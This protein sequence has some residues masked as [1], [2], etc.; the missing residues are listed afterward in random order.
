M[1]KLSSKVKYDYLGEDETFPIIVSSSLN[2]EQEVKLLSNFRKHRSAFGWS[3]TGLKGISPLICTHKIHLVEEVKPSREMH[4]RLNPIMKDVM[5]E[6][7][8]N[9]LDAVIIYP[10][11]NRKWVSHVQVI[12]KKSGMTVVKNAKVELVRLH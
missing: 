1:K 11:S 12:P 2:K 10:I 4:R 7:I 3:I 8:I 9:L 6:E 5:R